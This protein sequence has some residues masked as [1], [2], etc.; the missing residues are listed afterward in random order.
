MPERIPEVNG[1]S[2]VLVGSFNPTIFQPEWFVRQNLMQPTEGEAA[3]ITVLSPQISDFDTGRLKL[4]VTPQRF[5][6]ISSP[7]AN[8]ASVKDLVLGTFFIL[9]HTPVTAVGVNRQL[10]FGLESEDSWHRVGDK[11]APKEG[12][13]KILKG[14]PG[15]R[16][17]MIET[18][19]GDGHTTRVSVQP[20]QQVKSGVY[21]EVN[22]HYDALKGEGLKTLMNT[23]RDVWEDSYNYA[24][25][26]TQCILDW[27]LSG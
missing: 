24:A 1:V 19:N 14:R 5:V 15:M 11:L 16:S 25:E 17:L 6:A 13:N 7:D 12:W 10:H 20:S 21:F 26:I 2:V 22:Q 8:P 27:S 9:E 23:V 18:V 3:K 4:Q